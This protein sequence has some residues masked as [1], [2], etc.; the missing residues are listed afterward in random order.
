LDLLKGLQMAPNQNLYID[1][2]NGGFPSGKNTQ[3]VM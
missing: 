3:L 2:L 1:S